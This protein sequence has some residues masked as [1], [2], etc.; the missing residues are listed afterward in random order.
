ML[1]NSLFLLLFSTFFNQTYQLRQIE[2]PRWMP[3]SNEVLPQGV[4]LSPALE[5]QNK[6]RC[7][8][9]VVKRKERQC[10]ARHV[11][12]SIC[13]ERT[14]VWVADNLSLKNSFRLVNGVAPAP[15]R[16]RM[17]SFEP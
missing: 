8:C 16:D 17:M 15:R 10:I 7:Y 14:S 11:P 12:A 4:V 6:V 13:K 1:Y 9:E 5:L 2:C 3:G